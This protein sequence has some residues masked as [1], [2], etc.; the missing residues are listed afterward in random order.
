MGGTCRVPQGL[1]CARTATPMAVPETKVPRGGRAGMAAHPQRRKGT[2]GLCFQGAMG[3]A[4]L[5]D[6]RTT[7]GGGPRGTV[8]SSRAPRP[9]PNSMLSVLTGSTLILQ[10]SFMMW[11]LQG[12]GRSPNADVCF[13]ER[14][15]KPDNVKEETHYLRQ[16]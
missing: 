15:E 16:I 2:G 5:E 1:V 6:A 7:W 14:R 8:R 9:D 4:F 12:L 3:W 11:R 13:S 10:F